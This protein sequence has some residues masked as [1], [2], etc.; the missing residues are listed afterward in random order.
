MRLSSECCELENYPNNLIVNPRAT[1]NTN[2]NKNQ[3]I[4]KLEATP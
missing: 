2:K 1:N 4:E 3:E